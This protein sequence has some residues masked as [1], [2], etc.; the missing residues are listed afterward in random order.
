MKIKELF[1]TVNFDIEEEYEKGTYPVLV[2]D[3]QFPA[4]TSSSDLRRYKRQLENQ[5][6][7]EANVEIYVKEHL[8]A[9][10]LTIF[11]SLKQNT[12]SNVVTHFFNQFKVFCSTEFE[13]PNHMIGNGGIW[14]KGIPTINLEYDTINL[15]P[16][17]ST[18]SF[19][20]IE[21]KIT[22]KFLFLNLEK[23]AIGILSILKIPT[24]QEIVNVSSNPEQRQVVE[25]LSKYLE[26]KNIIAC[27]E[28]LFKNGLDE[29]AKL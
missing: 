12:S 14:L 6:S 25:I 5:F 19:K 11:S 22:C 8:I 7:T 27:Q 23:K 26:N 13:L 3:V 10:S 1:E 24:L 21:K 16:T 4:G 29:Y 2:T 18:K 9:L 17:D 20:G 28:E 15:A